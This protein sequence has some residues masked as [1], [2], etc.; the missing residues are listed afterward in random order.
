MNDR[1][2]GFK[3]ILLI[4]VLISAITLSHAQI[5]K[6]DVKQSWDTDTSQNYYGKSGAVPLSEFNN[7]I[8]ALSDK[9]VETESL[10]ISFVDNTILGILTVVIHSRTPKAALYF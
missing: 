7:L 4:M 8:A 2:A 6:R 5:N 3:I 10:E 9:G 1:P